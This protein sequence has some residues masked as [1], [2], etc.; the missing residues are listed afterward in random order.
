MEVGVI[1]T[2]PARSTTIASPAR[3][4]AESPTVLNPIS[5]PSAL[6][7]RA[8]AGALQRTTRRHPI[9]DGCRR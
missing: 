6:V 9:P 8:S 1:G 4:V 5:E 3:P 2:L 7:A